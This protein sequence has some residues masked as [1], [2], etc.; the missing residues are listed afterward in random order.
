[1]TTKPDYRSEAAKAYRRLYSTSAWKKRRAHQLGEFP[2]CRFCEAQGKTVLANV[3]DH[4]T[5]HRGDLDLFWHGELQSLCEPCHSITKQRIETF[6]FT[7]AADLDG[8]PVDPN[9]PANC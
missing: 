9:H 3:A 4:L 8:Y 5:P 1:M 6:G 2:L 7:S